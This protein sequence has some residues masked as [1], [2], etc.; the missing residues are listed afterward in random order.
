MS[1]KTCT[2]CLRALP[3]SSFGRRKKSPDGLQ[4]ACKQCETKRVLKWQSENRER[5]QS[6]RHRHSSKKSTKQYRRNWA[7]RKNYGITLDEFE[8]L[9]KIQEYKCAICNDKVKLRLDHDHLT[10]RIRGLLCDRCN[11]GIGVFKDDPTIL[12]AAIKYLQ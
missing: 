10:G 3:N 1:D 8:A 4:Y 2:K 6:T 9:A 5:A 12:Q 11:L 7:L